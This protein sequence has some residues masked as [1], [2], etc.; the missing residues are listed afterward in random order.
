MKDGRSYGH[1]DAPPSLWSSVAT[2]TTTR[3]P[4]PTAMASTLSMDVTEDITCLEY[5]TEDEN[6]RTDA[7]VIEGDGIVLYE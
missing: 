5:E 4:S 2:S 1:S 7:T 6:E 3:K